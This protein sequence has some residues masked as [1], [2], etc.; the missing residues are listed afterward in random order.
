MSLFNTK[1]T[2]SCVCI[3]VYI[4]V[5]SWLSVTNY[6]CV[7]VYVCI[8]HPGRNVLA[9]LSC[10]HALNVWEIRSLLSRGHILTLLVIRSASLWWWFD[11][12]DNDCAVVMLFIFRQIERSVGISVLFC[13]IILLWLIWVIRHVT[14]AAPNAHQIEPTG[15]LAGWLIMWFLYNTIAQDLQ[16]AWISNFVCEECVKRDWYPHF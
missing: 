11:D 14:C 9:C 12:V 6:D 7:F 13:E 3:C 15:W 4:V 10:L 16:K 8:V 1:Y 5:S 2:Y